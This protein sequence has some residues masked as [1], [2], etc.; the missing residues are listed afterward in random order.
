MNE[1]SPY[2]REELE[3]FLQSSEA[4]GFF[5]DREGHSAMLDRQTVEFYLSELPHPCQASLDQ[6]LGA[7]QEVRFILGGCRRIPEGDQVVLELAGTETIGQFASLLRLVEDGQRWHCMC[8]GDYAVEFRGA[9]STLAYLG[10]HHGQSL[11]WEDQWGG[12][13]I[14][15]E[16]ESLLI[17]LSE[18]GLHAP[19]QKFRKVQEAELESELESRAWLA[20]APD[21]LQAW[22]DQL[23]CEDPD[24]LAAIFE[25]SGYETP[26]SQVLGLLEWFACGYGRSAGTPL[27]QDFPR[28]LL[29]RVSPA[30]FAQGLEGRLTD[31]QMQGLQRYLLRGP[32][33]PQIVALPLQFKQHLL[34]EW[35]EPV[36][37]QYLLGPQLEEDYE[38]FRRSAPEEIVPFWERL[39]LGEFCVEEILRLHSRPLPEFVSELLSWSQSMPK[40]FEHFAGVVDRVIVCFKLPLLQEI[41]LECASRPDL[42]AG[43]ARHLDHAGGYPHGSF[44]HFPAEFSERIVHI[45]E[46]LTGTEQKRLRWRLYGEPG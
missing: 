7:T 46:Q 32:V 24:V 26:D 20:A 23:F 1:T 45:R 37:L 8:L 12:D 17:W 43:V 29:R 42:I 13:G 40:A 35:D 31:L 22:G 33:L 36:Q 5:T 38:R 44:Q 41:L 14:L 9:E 11:R 21:Y 10:F 28:V 2:P 4:F 16:P 19:L 18:R 30:R 34:A 15:A 6:L 25:T 27:Y 39:L 3:A